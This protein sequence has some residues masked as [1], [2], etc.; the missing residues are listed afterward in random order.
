MNTVVF[1]GPSLSGERIR[2][3]TSSVRIEN[4]IRRG[5]MHRLSGF[6]TFV[7]LDGEF[8]QSLSV[9]PKELLDAIDS[10]KRVIGASSMG[11]LRAS[12]LDCYGM[13]GIGWVYRRFARA[14]V[15]RD[16]EV[17]LVFSPFDF[18]PVTIP[19]VCVEYWLE[20]LRAAGVLS[21]KE[22]K[23]MSKVI[24]RIFFAER[25]EAS[26]LKTIA[27]AFGSDTLDK[28]LEHTGGCIPDIK[29]LDAEEAI[30]A[31]SGTDLFTGQK[32]DASSS[33]KERADQYARAI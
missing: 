8:G 6:D 21:P 18:K 22:S 24:G 11:A 1:A 29:A 3:I 15:R 14:R 30:R 27:S 33:Q 17:A 13:I 4:P 5:D 25:T 19:M 12:E 28:M 31:A 10:G 16:D 7:I 26:L 20:V 32:N 2:A 23:T 9:S